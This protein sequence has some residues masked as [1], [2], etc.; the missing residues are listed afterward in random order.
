MNP[1]PLFQQI[2]G[3]CTGTVE[4]ASR[5]RRLCNPRQQL[6]HSMNTIQQYEATLARRLLAGLA[7]PSLLTPAATADRLHQPARTALFPEAPVL[8]DALVECGALASCWSGAGPSLLG[9]TR[10]ASAEKVAAGA[11]SALEQSGLSGRVLV[12]HADRR[13]LVYGED[14][15]LPD[16]HHGAV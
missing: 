3:H 9:I 6:V 10:H 12:L 7:E 5:G 14:A 1:Q 13:G 11:R 16:L 4:A 2:Y 8:L 15:A